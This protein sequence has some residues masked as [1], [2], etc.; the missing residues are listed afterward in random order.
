MINKINYNVLNQLLFGNGLSESETVYGAMAAE[1][2]KLGCNECALFEEAKVTGEEFPNYEEMKKNCIDGLRK[3]LAELQKLVTLDRASGADVELFLEGVDV[4][5]IKNMSDEEIFEIG[6]D[7]DKNY[8]PD[9]KYRAY[10]MRK[11][12]DDDEA[13][14]D[15]GRLFLKTSKQLKKGIDYSIKNEYNKDS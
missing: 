14:D 3:Q 15:L 12:N 8:V 5:D 9:P 1:V 10:K 6:L 7:V 4:K 11:N 2:V 13:L